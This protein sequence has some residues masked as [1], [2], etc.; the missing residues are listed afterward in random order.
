MR[1]EIIYADPA[2]TMK[3]PH[4]EYGTPYGTMTDAEIIAL[5][6]SEIADKNSVLLM[7]TIS[8]KLPIAIEAIKQWGFEYKTIAFT[9]I[10]TSKKTGMPN[11][12]LSPYTL[13]A[14]EICLLAMRGRIKRS[15]FRVRQVLL[16]PREAHSK[17]PDDIRERIV[18]LFGNRRRIELFA[19]QK[20]EGWDAW[21]DE[22]PENER[23]KIFT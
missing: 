18:E 13:G 21:G 2:W 4:E 23:A 20:H 6:V 9:W 12:R 10:K 22:I 5:P 16:S 15:S 1:Y 11:C 17:K 19:R 7:W 8:S 3:E 14:T